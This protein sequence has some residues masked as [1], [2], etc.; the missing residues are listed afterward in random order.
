MMSGLAV[1]LLNGLAG[2]S[3]LFLIAVGLSLIFG[4]SRIVNFAHGSMTMIGLYVAY[5]LVGVLG[6]SGVAWW[7]GVL[8]AAL[9]V[10]ALGALIEIGV[11][12][13]VYHAPE[14]FQ[15]LATF[16][17]VLILRD[18][19]LWI[20]GPEDLFGPKAPGMKGAVDI[21]G[22]AFPQYDLFLIFV[23]PVVLLALW[24][25]LRRTRAGIL[26]RAATQDREMVGAL[27]VNQAW[28]FTGVFALGSA[29]AALGGALQLPREPANLGL[30]LTTIGEAFVVVVVGGMGSIPGA[31]LAALL[32]AE[33]KAL[34]YGLGTVELFG[35]SFSMSKLTLV[36][37]FLVMAAVLVWRPWGLLGRPQANVRSAAEAEAPMRPM[38]RG[39]QLA[40][41]CVFA[42]LLMVP[43]L[44]EQF[45]YAT[46]LLID[47]LI[48]ALFAASLHFVMGPGGMHSFGHAAYFGL[49]AY[50]AALLLRGA[51]LPMEA[52][53]VLGP[54]VALV[55][56]V[57]FGWFAVRL[58]GVYLAM[59]TLAFAQ[60]VWS[61]VFQWDDVTGGSNGLVGIWPA[62]WL[63]SKTAYYWLTL[64][65]V[66]ASLY[67]LRRLLFSPLGYAMRAGR[68]SPL[69]A[70]ATGIDVVRQH[71]IAFSVAGLF[72]GLAGALFAF[73]K[74]SISPEAISVGRSVDG[75]VMVLLGG[76]QTL[77]GPV[78]GAGV[79]TWLQ[80]SVSRATEYWRAL[81][82]AVVLG[83]VILFPQGIAGGLLALVARMRGTDDAGTAA[84][85]GRR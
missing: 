72:C 3:T 24:L 19:A 38:G 13:R 44:G 39:A 7:A 23:G 37:E 15:L 52:A 35:T 11:L 31:Y 36:V 49:G 64:A 56:A 80:D 33:I 84:A 1:Q 27:G 61:V 50:G 66:G 60:I 65:T 26:I 18:A 14:L 58:S 76:V 16:A 81:L 30:D 55:G 77:A 73:A 53:L 51:A 29:L 62:E 17:V 83:L 28:L 10:G 34:C 59:L 68:D 20:W 41:A 47:M 71:W 8:I 74:G 75:L 25:L 70:E 21:L 5:T 85:G 54:L 9:A 48:A 6:D 69:R 57:V 4:V 67:L 40:V 43:W 32:I 22:R 82:G 46:V 45:P 79:F 78:V 12:R 42:V 2:A 63:S